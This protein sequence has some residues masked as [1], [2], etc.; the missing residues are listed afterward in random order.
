M[1][2]SYFANYKGLDAVSIAVGS[3]KWYS[4]DK[5]PELMPTWKM[6]K[7]GYSYEEYI[8]LLKSRGLTAGEVYEKYKG[9]VL[10]CWE[11][12]RSECHRGML[13][14]WIKEEIGIEIKEWNKLQQKELFFN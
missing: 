9:K 2:T 10:L 5:A 3:P 7:A 6:V 14:R 12:D 13:A 4:G 8:E 1:Q 11:K